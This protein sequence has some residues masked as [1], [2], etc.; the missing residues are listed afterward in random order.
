MKNILKGKF[1]V[2]S[3]A[4]KHNRFYFE[5]GRMFQT[6]KSYTN[7][8]TNKNGPLLCQPLVTRADKLS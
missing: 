3:A 8:K 5:T 6:G 1:R 2:E 4:R 7:G